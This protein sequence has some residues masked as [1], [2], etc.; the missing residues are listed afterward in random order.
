MEKPLNLGITRD[1]AEKKRTKQF[2]LSPE[3]IVK[4]K[5]Y[6]TVLVATIDRQV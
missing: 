1:D 6:N 5:R 3:E 2:D 4:R